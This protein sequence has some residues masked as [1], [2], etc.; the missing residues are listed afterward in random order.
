MSGVKEFLIKP[1]NV[2]GPISEDDYKVACWKKTIGLFKDFEANKEEIH[3][4]NEVENLSYPKFISE[5][6][7]RANEQS[8]ANKIYFNGDFINFIRSYKFDFLTC[9]TDIFKNNQLSFTYY[10]SKD[11]NKDL[12][13]IGDFIDMIYKLPS[14]SV[15]IYE[16]K[17][18]D[19]MIGSFK[20]LCTSFYQIDKL[21]DSSLIGLSHDKVISSYYYKLLEGLFSKR[22]KIFG[23]TKGFEDIELYRCRL[24]IPR[25][26]SFYSK[27]VSIFFRF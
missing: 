16:A 8:L 12:T 23:P 9:T 15:E 18:Q 4:L 7:S 1:R 13:Y 6:R 26:F 11:L 17:D 22:K 2:D 19:Q 20:G 21:N 27:Y 14:I 10:Q 5:L 24:V 25:P 3:A